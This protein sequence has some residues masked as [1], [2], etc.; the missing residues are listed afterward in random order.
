MYEWKISHQYLCY[1]AIAIP[2]MGSNKIEWNE[3][4]L[5]KR[6]ALNL[7]NCGIV[8]NIGGVERL[9]MWIE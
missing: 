8:C 3:I 9:M 7:K 2:I 1:S 6:V 5:D 4:D